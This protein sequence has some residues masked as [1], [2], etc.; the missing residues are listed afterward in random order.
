LDEVHE[1]NPVDPPKDYSST[2]TSSE[3]NNYMLGSFQSNQKKKMLLLFMEAEESSSC[4]SYNKSIR[5]SPMVLS[6]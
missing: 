1:S 5:A 3:K 4:G 2:G 6:M